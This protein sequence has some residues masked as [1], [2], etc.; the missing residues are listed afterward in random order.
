MWLGLVIS[1]ILF[2]LIVDH[3]LGIDFRSI[4]W[5]VVLYLMF[6]LGAT[7][8]MIG[9][10]AQAGR[11]WA[12]VIAPIFLITATLSFIQRSMTGVQS[13]SVTVTG[14]FLSATM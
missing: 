6:F 2:E 1:F 10:A 3:I 13:F 8:G 11:P 14:L 7:G 12:V 9:V 5:A 4:Q